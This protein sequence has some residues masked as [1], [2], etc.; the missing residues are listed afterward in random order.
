[1]AP[2]QEALI[3]HNLTTFLADNLKEGQ[4]AELA[5]NPELRHILVFVDG[6]LVLT[7]GFDELLAGPGI[8]TN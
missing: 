5:I 6:E 7:C 8:S 3:A 1:M 4:E 2:D